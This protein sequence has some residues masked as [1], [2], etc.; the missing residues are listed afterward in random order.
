VTAGVFIKDGRG[1]GRRAGLTRNGS[2]LVTLSSSGEP[3]EPDEEPVFKATALNVVCGTSKSMLSLQNVT[4][5]RII[6]RIH[7][8]WVKPTQTSAVTGV[9]T[10][11]KTFRISTHSGGTLVDSVAYDTNDVSSQSITI[12]TGATVTGEATQVLDRFMSSSDEW[13]PGTLDTEGMDA[14]FARHFPVFKRADKCK[15]ITV[16]QGEG[17]HIKC[18]TTTTVGTFDFAFLYSQV[19]L[20]A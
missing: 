5:S 17:V 10:S 7:E 8:I 20:E 12:R 2:L 4:G 14:A 18:D 13:G 15:P 16:R 1:T 6:C 9:A 11:F 19:H 3:L